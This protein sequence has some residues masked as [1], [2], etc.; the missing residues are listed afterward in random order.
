M[1]RLLLVWVIAMYR[2][3]L[4]LVGLLGL[5]VLSGC[6]N[7]YPGLNATEPD[8]DSCSYW[9][10]CDIPDRTTYNVSGSDC[11]DLEPGRA[12]YLWHWLRKYDTTMYAEC[13]RE[14]EVQG[15]GQLYIRQSS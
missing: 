4:G 12:S 6:G 15:R 14:T 2:G 5:L 10:V 9:R 8:W 1:V 7:Q 11:M 3:I 13:L